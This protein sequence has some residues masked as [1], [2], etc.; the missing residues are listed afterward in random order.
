[1]KNDSNRT[2]TAK[3][4]RSF[5]SFSTLATALLAFVLCGCKSTD[6]SQQAEIARAAAQAQ[7]ADAQE[8][9]AEALILREGDAVRITFPG[10]PNLNTVQAIR[11][12]GKLALPLVGEVQAA[13]LA[14]TALEKKLIDLYGPQL[15][16]KEVTVSLESSAFAVYVT[17]AVLRPGKVISD[18]PITALEA[19]MEAGGFDF[20][21][22]NLKKVRVIRNIKGTPEYYT[23]DLKKVMNGEQT[24]PFPLKPSDILYVPERF[25][26]F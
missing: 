10:A 21:K 11:R 14:P 8:R 2:T 19:I 4:A 3:W 18:R 9:P 6:N 24:T 1:M 25:S 17:G 13:G 23:L 16:T 22:A 26:W 7:A 15:Q 5:F 12:D 20:N